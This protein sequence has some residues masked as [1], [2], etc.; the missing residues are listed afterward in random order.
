MRSVL[1]QEGVKVGGH[2]RRVPVLRPDNLA[3]NFPLAV[4][5]VRFW[6]HR[7]AVILGNGRAMIVVCARVAIRGE[8]HSMIANEVF[9]FRLILI[10]SNTKDHTVS[11]GNVLFERNQAGDFF[12]AG[13]APASP[14]IQNHDLATKVGKMRGLPVKL[15]GEIFGGFSGDGG[16]ALAVV[17]EGK[18]SQDGKR[19]T[20]AAPGE[21]FAEEGI[22]MKL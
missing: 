22:H 16:F 4:N 5:H 19:K 17:R 14:K 2:F 12:H 15:H 10:G 20:H 13:R 7:C 18:E 6:I 3:D 1:G 8:I 9:V 11:G 21:E